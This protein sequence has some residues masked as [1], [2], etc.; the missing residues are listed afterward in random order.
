MNE[1]E[2][3]Q[4]VE[5]ALYTL[6]KGDQRHQPKHMAGLVDLIIRQLGKPISSEQIKDS[7][8]RIIL[9]VMRESLETEF[10]FGLRGNSV[11]MAEVGE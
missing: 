5:S 6:T 10:S 2:L 11:P 7:L 4:V 1:Q 9:K 3:D 8:A